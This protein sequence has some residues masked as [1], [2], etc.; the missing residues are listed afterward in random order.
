MKALIWSAVVAASLA[1]AGLAVAHGLDGTKA[2]QK[3]AGTF[4]ATTAS[5]DSKT[6]TCTVPGG[7]SFS[8][9]RGTFT[10]TATGDPDLTGP[11]RLD[12]S[13]TID[14]TKNIGLVEGKLRI[15]VASG[16]DTKAH[17]SAVYSG[18]NIAGLAVGDGAEPFARLIGNLSA[19]FS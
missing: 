18:G 5:A 13:S 10:G 16:A 7:D 9:S 2:A 12:V 15:D 19:G 8:F 11:I 14:T 1:T 3:V 17:F 6:R 4:T